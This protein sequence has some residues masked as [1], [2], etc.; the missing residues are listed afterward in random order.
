MSTSRRSRARKV[1]F[2][3]L[4][5]SV[6]FML[7]LSDRV[8]HG[9]RKGVV[10]KANHAAAQRWWRTLPDDASPARAQARLDTWCARH[11][12]KDIYG[13]SASRS[14]RPPR[15]QDSHRTLATN[16]PRRLGSNCLV[17]TG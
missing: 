10:E 4:I 8:Q 12:L 13:Q 11:G 7:I 15:C 2:Y 5:L 17:V 6:A 1:R 9:W 14:R 16:P 3:V